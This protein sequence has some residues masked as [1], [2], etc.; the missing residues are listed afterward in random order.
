MTAKM[1]VSI[2]VFTVGLGTTQLSGLDWDLTVGGGI[3]LP[4]EIVAKDE[5]QSGDFQVDLKK[6]TAPLARLAFDLYPLP[7]V[8]GGVFV[9]A[10]GAPLD[11]EFSL[12]FW[13]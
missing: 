2:A 4:G 13:D 6:P 5:L 10:G 12:G 1:I 8:G 3:S 11:E 9:F 7:G